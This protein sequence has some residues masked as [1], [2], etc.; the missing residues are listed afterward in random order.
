VLQGIVPRTLVVPLVM[1][2][3]LTGGNALAAPSGLSASEIVAKNIQAKGGLAAWRA[4]KTLSFAGTMDAGGKHNA[5][6][7]FVMDLKRPRKSRV[8]IAFENDKAI[9]VYDGE[10]G[11]KLRPFLNRR[12]VEP[13]TP[14]ELQAASQEADLDGPLVDYAAK[15]TSVELEGTEQVEGRDTYRL[16]LTEKGKVRHL[17]IDAKTFLEVKIDG[18]PRR[19]DGRMRHVEVYYRD[20]RNVDG[21]MI[22]HVVE[23]AVQGVRQPHKMVI[24]TVVVNPKLDDALFTAPSSSKT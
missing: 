20:F 10:R 14:E 5:Q 2:G 7:P 11:W 13:F 18:T 21:L 9:Q 24:E 22:P 6:L 3:L 4:V 8:E 1:L 23:T 17:W 15:G 12:D 19:M 16:K